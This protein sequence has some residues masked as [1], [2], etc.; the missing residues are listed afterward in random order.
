MQKRY[1]YQRRLWLYDRVI[2]QPKMQGV[3]FAGIFKGK[4]T[5]KYRNVICT[6]GRA[7]RGERRKCRGAGEGR[8]Q[9]PKAS[10]LHEL[11][12]EPS[13]ILYLYERKQRALNFHH[14]TPLSLAV[15]LIQFGWK[16]RASSFLCMHL[17]Y[18]HFEHA[19]SLYLVWTALSPTLIL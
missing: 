12:P 18:A 10:E 4:G 14:A 2:N 15:S 16:I 11:Q 9:A 3:S 17:S 5:S 19:K 13:Y 7:R 1:L 8:G 6:R